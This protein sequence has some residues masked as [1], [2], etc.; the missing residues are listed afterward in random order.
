MSHL[1]FPGS[2]FCCQIPEIKSKILFSFPKFYK[3]LRDIRGFNCRNNLTIKDKMRIMFR[4]DWCIIMLN[5][6]NIY[7]YKL[8]NCSWEHYSLPWIASL[9]LDRYLIMLNV[10]QRGIKYYF[11][12]LWYDLIW[13]WTQVSQTIGEHSNNYAN[14]SCGNK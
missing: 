3:Y 5:F 11:L 12:S 6:L 10:K 1:L 9:T 13:D 14:G 7:I 4:K 8:V 2:D